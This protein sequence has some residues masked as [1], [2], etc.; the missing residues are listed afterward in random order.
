MNIQVSKTTIIEV[1]KEKNKE[2]WKSKAVKW[3]GWKALTL[4]WPGKRSKSRERERERGKRRRRRRSRSRSSW[5]GGRGRESIFFVMKIVSTTLHP[6]TRTKSRKH[7]IQQTH[8]SNNQKTTK[9]AQPH[10]GANK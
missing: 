8:Q 9:A 10:I 5:V 1:G 6:N 2:K 4:T 7:E 3:R